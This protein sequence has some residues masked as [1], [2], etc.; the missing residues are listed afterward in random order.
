MDIA[1]AFAAVVAEQRNSYGPDELT[2]AECVI[3]AFDCWDLDGEVG[4]DA[5][6]AAVGFRFLVAE[7]AA[8]RFR[9]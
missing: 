3:D 6:D 1:T 5:T 7:Q 8:G 9:L 2:D 4:A